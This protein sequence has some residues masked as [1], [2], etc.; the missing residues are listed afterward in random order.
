VV[1]GYRSPVTSEVPKDLIE[2]GMVAS[3]Y[4]V[5]GWFKVKPHAL[6]DT[7]LVVKQWWLKFPD[8]LAKDLHCAMPLTV[9]A[10]KRHN[11]FIVAQA[12]QISN[13]DT[14]ESLKGCSVWVSRSHFPATLDDE[15]YWVDLFGL[16]AIN[17]QNQSL[18]EVVGL[19]DNGAHP[20]LRLV[21]FDINKAGVEIKRE[22]LIPF[23]KA[24]LCEID[25]Q[26][27]SVCIDWQLDY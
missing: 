8:Q 17:L 21:Y 19:L 9:L 7:L 16:T 14:S 20:I 1:H 10:A 27:K 18:G 23:V 25:W 22:R 12:Q 3:A 2:L 15:Y 13:R 24:Y 6:V 11:H 26:N 5:Y 4:G